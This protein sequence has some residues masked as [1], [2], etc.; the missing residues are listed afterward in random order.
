M[1]HHSSSS[2]VTKTGTVMTNTNGDNKLVQDNYVNSIDVTNGAQATMGF[3]LILLNLNQ[4]QPQMQPQVQPF[5][6]Q[7]RM[8]YNLA[9]GM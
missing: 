5:Q 7:T 8:P 9:Y 2:T 3:G 6:G 4:M 1:G